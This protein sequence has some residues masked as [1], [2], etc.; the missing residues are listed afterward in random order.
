MYPL[1][2]ALLI[3]FGCLALFAGTD[4]APAAFSGTPAG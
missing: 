3:A 2:T 1:R 4:A